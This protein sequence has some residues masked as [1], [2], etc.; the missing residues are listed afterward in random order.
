MSVGLYGA[1]VAMLL[2]TLPTLAGLKTDAWAFAIGF[3]PFV[4]LLAHGQL[5]AVAL[6][7]VVIAYVCF[8]QDRFWWTGVALGS[9]VFKPQLGTFV[10]VALAVRPSRAMLGGAA[11]AAV[12]QVA[13]GALALGPDVLSDYLQAVGRV[14]RHPEAFEPKPWALHSLRGAF[15]LLLGRGGAATTLWLLASGAVIVLARRAAHAADDSGVRFA[16]VV[17]AAML[18]NPHMYVY[19]LVLLVVPLAILG[20]RQLE[21]CSRD[22]RVEGLVYSLIWLPLLAPAAALT[23]VQLTPLVMTALL[24]S[25]SYR[26]VST[27]QAVSR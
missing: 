11:L 4:Q 13:I 7:I 17:I 24:W 27:T 18:V 16:V 20:A 21:A 3:P 19:D 14:L 10:L 9:L 15:E 2:R 12:T 8:R 25:L 22:R 6:A 26:R 1:A 5:S 23:R